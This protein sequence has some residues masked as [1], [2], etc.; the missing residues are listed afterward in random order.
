MEEK[1]NWF[2]HVEWAVMLITL[3][4]GFYTLDAKIERQGQ[5]TDRLLEMF[6]EGMRLQSERTDALYQMFIDLV[7][8]NKK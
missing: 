1:R 5:R 7:K 3:L 8:E 6:C 4:G 2:I